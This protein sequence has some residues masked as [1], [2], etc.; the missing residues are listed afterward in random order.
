[1]IFV[2]IIFVLL[3][4]HIAYSDMASR[5]IKNIQILFLL[6]LGGVGLC[7]EGVDWFLK[8][9][10]NAA[11][12][13]FGFFCGFLFFYAFKMM[14]AADVKLAAALALCLGWERML[15][16]WLLS[17]ALALVYAA[18]AN[19]FPIMKLKMTAVHNG[20]VRRND[21]KFDRFVPYGALLCFAAIAVLLVRG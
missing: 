15:W 8:D 19:Y 17:V 6:V 10:A 3:L 18:A 13:F 21:K 12:S 16:V 20:A 14:G 4:C 1:M 11:F 9:A 7:V 5:K 2:K